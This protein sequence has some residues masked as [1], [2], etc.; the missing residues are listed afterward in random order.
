MRVDSLQGPEPPA[1]GE[2]R[3]RE[4]DHEHAGEDEDDRRPGWDVGV[5][6]HVHP[7]DAGGRS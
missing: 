3:H 5:V 6:R 2:G 1:S 7:E 4:D